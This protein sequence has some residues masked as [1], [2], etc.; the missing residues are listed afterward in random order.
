MY[1]GLTLGEFLTRHGALVGSGAYL[2]KL[3]AYDHPGVGVRYAAIWTRS[4]R[5]YTFPVVNILARDFMGYRDVYASIG[6][7]IRS[8][9]VRGGRYTVVFERTPPPI[10]VG[11]P[12]VS[13][14]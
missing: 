4:Q 13:A 3:K 1:Y 14:N 12:V 2:V 10:V 11:P 7:R 8:L 9:T 6:Y 5:Q